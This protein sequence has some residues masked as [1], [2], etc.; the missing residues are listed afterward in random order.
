MSRAGGLVLGGIEK[1]ENQMKRAIQKGFTLIE[2]V[3][4]IIILGILA[5]VAVPQFIDI[6]ADA[7]TAVAKGACGALQSSA[8]LLYASK[9]TTSTILQIQTN[10]ATTADLSFAGTCAAPTATYTDASGGTIAACGAIPSG[11]CL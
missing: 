11:L 9:K 2:L 10:T 4:V 6:A 8:V 3:V 7:R 1:R 5:A